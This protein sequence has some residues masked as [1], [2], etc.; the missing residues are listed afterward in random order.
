M[1]RVATIRHSQDETASAE[2]GI[3]QV[4]IRQG[5]YPLGRRKAIPVAILCLS[6]HHHFLGVDVDLDT[7]G[8]EAALNAEALCGPDV[9]VAAEAVGQAP[10]TARGR[11]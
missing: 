6:P 5:R 8:I 11:E 2:D 3:A 4:A 9:G 7:A 1:G 10:E